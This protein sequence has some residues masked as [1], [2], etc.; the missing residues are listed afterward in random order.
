MQLRHLQTLIPYAILGTG[1]IF[2]ATFLRPPAT[3]GAQSSVAA[4]S[5][6]SFLDSQAGWPEAIAAADAGSSE[7]AKTATLP[8]PVEASQVCS[9]WLQDWADPVQHEAQLEWILGFITG[10]N[11][12]TEGQGHPG[13]SD[14]VEI[15]IEHY[16]RNNPE[17][18]LFMAAAALV[19]ETGGPIAFHAFKKS[20]DGAS[21]N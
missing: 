19:Q 18:Q 14:E 10:S 13:S 7:K 5:P 21:K 12:R 9:A 6:N 20:A 1:V 3:T 11:Y 4:P 17:D 8:P 2:V 16:C 15:F